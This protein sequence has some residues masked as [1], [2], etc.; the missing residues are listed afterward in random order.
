[1][2]GVLA[3]AGGR[4]ALP[5]VVGRGIGTEGVNQLDR[6]GHVRGPRSL[7]AFEIE[8]DGVA[9]LLAQGRATSPCSPP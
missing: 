8:V 7:V 1:M 4:E 2:L 5:R 3:P 6:H 9:D